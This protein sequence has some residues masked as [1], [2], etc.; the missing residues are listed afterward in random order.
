MKVD[1]SHIAKLSN[2][3]LTSVEQ[4]TL[5][6]QFQDTL[7]FVAKLKD[8]DVTKVQGTPTVTDLKNRFRKDIVDPV[9]Q[10]TSSQ[11]LSNAKSTH[12]G[13]FVVESILKDRS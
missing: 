1:V 12:K 7:G 2:L 3:T 13:F 9:R 5:S 11:A 4:K 8:L 6:R 10:L